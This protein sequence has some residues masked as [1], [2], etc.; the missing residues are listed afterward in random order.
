MAIARLRGRSWGGSV[1]FGGVVL[2]AA[3]AVVAI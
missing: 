3:L 2:I 1:L